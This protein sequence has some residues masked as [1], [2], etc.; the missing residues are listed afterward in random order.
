MVAANQGEQTRRRFPALD[1][2]PPPRPWWHWALLPSAAV[3]IAAVT[4]AAV[5]LWPSAHRGRPVT[6]GPAAP[7]ITAGGRVVVQLK[8]GSLEEADPD[9][10]H[11]QPL[12]ALGRL[13][14][15]DLPGFGTVA[16]SPDNR[17]LAL[18][19]GEL[20]TLSG[21][22]PAVAATKLRFNSQTTSTYLNPFADHDRAL[23]SVYDLY[24]ATT[25]APIFVSDVAT[26]HRAGLGTGDQAS[27]DP[28]A[29]GAFVS[30]AAPVRPSATVQDN[31]LSPDARLELRDIGHRPVRLVTAGQVDRM[32][33]QPVDLQV[34]MVPY[35]D[36]SGDKVAVEVAAIAGGQTAAIV[37]L[38][39]GGHLIDSVQAT[40]GP[41]LKQRLT[42]SPDGQLLAFP[43]LGDG[44]TELTFWTVG[45]QVLT[46]QFLDPSDTYGSCLWAP[47]GSAVMC[48]AYRTP[49]RDPVAW[50]VANTHGGGM[51][52]VTS[53]GTPVAWLAAA[54]RT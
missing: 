17:Y 12:T 6:G 5:N 52:W 4:I 50:T 32:L 35:P 42:W 14:G 2:E 15:V 3:T 37:V 24:G 33:G 31:Q 43:T 45:G 10:R 41:L 53:P 47:D 28:R 13:P 8:D 9:G 11:R 27:G 44:G 40:M 38:D 26:G 18:G 49:K 25:S 36:P 39:R 16:V 48:A 22:R 19:D 51:V 30:V 20:I 54:G 21:G 34:A 1:P 7:V 46:T 29:P 23:V